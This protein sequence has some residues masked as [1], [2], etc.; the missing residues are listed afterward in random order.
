MCERILL[1]RIQTHLLENG[2][3]EKRKIVLVNNKCDPAIKNIIHDI[4]QAKIYSIIGY[5][6]KEP[7]AESKYTYLGSIKNIDEIFHHHSFD[8]ILYIESDYS[9][10]SMYTLWDYAR[11][12]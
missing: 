5:I 6:N 3:L 4:K 8:E 12:F 9:H 7:L 11:I 10:K 1:N 2:F